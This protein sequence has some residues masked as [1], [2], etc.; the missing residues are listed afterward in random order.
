VLKTRIKDLALAAISRLTGRHAVL[1]PAEACGGILPVEAP[2]RVEGS[3]LEIAIG[4]PAAGLLSVEL[5][6]YDGFLPSIPLL[7]AA[8]LPYPGPS[9]LALD[10]DSGI[11]RLG[12]GEVGRVPPLPQRFTFRLAWRAAG[13]V[14]GTLRRSTGHYRPTATDT[15]G[16]S[17]EESGVGERYFAGDNYVDHERQSAGE[18]EEIAGWLAGAGVAGPVLEVGCATGGVLA[19]LERH[20]HAAYGLD[21]SAWAI[22]R[23]RARV[24]A[25]RAFHCDAAND[26]FPAEVEARAPFG[27]LVLWSVLEHF[28]DPFATLERLT[29]LTAPGSVLLVQTTNCRSLTSRLFGNDWEERS[30]W[31]HLGID[32]VSPESV[33]RELPRLG[34]RLERLTSRFLLTR[35]ADPSHATLREWYAADARFRGLLAEKDLGDM[36]LFLARRAAP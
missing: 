7:R 6:G 11:L 5:L 26:P 34:W 33:R 28:A 17:L 19:V 32:R 18:G 13:G 16:E 29:R 35:S 36:I 25:G 8:D 14:A 23:A 2:Y 27:A 21:F 3:R 24:G 20:G 15:A 12:D 9:R 30:D 4:A 1:L 22:E 10:L 31:T